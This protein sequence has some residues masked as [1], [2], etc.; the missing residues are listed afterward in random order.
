MSEKE[1]YL[2]QINNSCNKIVDAIDSIYES[3]NRLE[4]LGLPVDAA[5]KAR[6]DIIG[7]LTA[8]IDSGI[9]VYPKKEIEYNLS[10]LLTD[11]EQFEE[12]EELNDE[13][14]NEDT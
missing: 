1:Y 10:D 14:D 7:S 2:K 6:E 12:I 13:E 8:A 4:R 11:I 9:S 3:I 5:D